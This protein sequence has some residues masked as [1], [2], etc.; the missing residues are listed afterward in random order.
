MASQET[1]EIGENV[2][3]LRQ[4]L[5]S[6]YINLSSAEAHLRRGD[7]PSP[8]SKGW[9][10]SQALVLPPR[11]AL[12]DYRSSLARRLQLLSPMPAVELRKLQLAQ[13][14][15]LLREWLFANRGW[16]KRHVARRPGSAY[17]GHW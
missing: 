9:Q 8:M 6:V 2:L 7:L 12:T 1:Y 17:H 5:A 10:G 16:Y 4:P 11:T 3:L 14:S 15:L 13:A